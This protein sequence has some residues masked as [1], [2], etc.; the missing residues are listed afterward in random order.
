VRTTRM[1]TGDWYVLDLSVS[2]NFQNYCGLSVVKRSSAVP[3]QV[4]PLSSAQEPATSTS[5]F[6][7]RRQVMATSIPEQTSKIM[8]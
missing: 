3:V 5:Q 2:P 6:G 7:V 8:R 1:P 4:Q